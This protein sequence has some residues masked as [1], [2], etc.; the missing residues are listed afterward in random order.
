MRLAPEPRG[1]SLTVTDHGPGIPKEEHARIFERFYRLGH[2]LRRETTG[3]GIGLAIVQHIVEGH[4]GRISVQS[5]MGKGSAF[6]M[7]FSESE[8]GK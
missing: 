5:E 7:V 2:E 6:R 4:G 8:S 3:T 1:W